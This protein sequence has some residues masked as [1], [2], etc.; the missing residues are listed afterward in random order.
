MKM[1]AFTRVSIFHASIHQ[2]G[3]FFDM[4]FLALMLLLSPVAALL[5]IAAVI[6]LLIIGTIEGCACAWLIMKVFARV[7]HWFWR[8]FIRATAILWMF[9]AAVVLNSLLISA[10]ALHDHIV[11]AS[12]APL[13][14]VIPFLTLIIIR[15]VIS[16]VRL[17]RTLRTGKRAAVQELVQKLPRALFIIAGTLFMICAQ[18]L[19][20][21]VI[22]SIVRF[23]GE[24]CMIIVIAVF[25]VF[26]S[27]GAVSLW[28]SAGN[29]TIIGK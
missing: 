19:I 6:L 29:R 23:P 10:C 9:V 17:I 22:L 26:L 7:R 15:A 16:V 13:I 1:I 20:A 5:G 8:H 21:S 25:S 28:Y 12:A 18:I 3:D 27:I 24:T 14:I 2:T 11:L 4:A